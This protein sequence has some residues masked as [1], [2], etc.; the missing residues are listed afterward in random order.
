[1]QRVVSGGDLR[2]RFKLCEIGVQLAQNVL[3]ALE[4]LARILKT[5]FR[6]AAALFVLGDTGGFFEEDAQLLGTGFDNARDHALTNDGV[7]ARAQTGAEEDI[8]HITPTHCLIVDVVGRGT[9]AREYALDRDLGEAAP[10]SR[11]LS[12]TVVEQQLNRGAAGWL[13]AGRAIENDVLHGLAA[14]LGCLGFAQH[15]AHGVDDVGLA[16]AIRTDDTH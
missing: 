16:A 9:V 3:H 14:Q 6:L 12:G 7:R 5:I 1:M 10:L 15:P 8:L 4:V 11:S 2:L 13:A